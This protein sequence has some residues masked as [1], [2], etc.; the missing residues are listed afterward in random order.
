MILSYHVFDGRKWLSDDEKTWTD[1]FHSSAYFNDPKLAQDIGTH[2][3][4]PDISI[5]VMA[6]LGWI[7]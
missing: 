5:Y 1:D 2:Q 6:V 7:G 3:I 4:N